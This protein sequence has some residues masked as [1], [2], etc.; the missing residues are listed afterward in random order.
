MAIEKHM[1]LTHSLFEKAGE[2]FEGVAKLKE[3]IAE[4]K[5]NLSEIQS[6]K[7]QLEDDV[8]LLRRNNEELRKENEDLK[9]ELFAVKTDLAMSQ[10]WRDFKD[11]PPEHHQWIEACYCKDMT[12]ERKPRI[13]I[14]R[15]DEGMK[16]DVFE[17]ELF[18]GWRPLPNAPEVK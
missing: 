8:A 1:L 10:R 4:L 11:E 15:W 5:Q 2:V 16:Y 3:R 12:S 14:R 13:E 9:N 18:V 6:Q 17:Q 7:M